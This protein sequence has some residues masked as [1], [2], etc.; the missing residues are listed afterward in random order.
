M[1]FVFLVMPFEVGTEV[2][3]RLRQAS[4]FAKHQRQ[5]QSTDTTIP[6]HE[7]M[8]RFELIM[9][10]GQLDHDRNSPGAF[11]NFSKSAISGTSFS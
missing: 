8:D 1:V 10:Q 7:R 11:R 4:P 6:I 9:S 3:Q 2:Q 5:Q